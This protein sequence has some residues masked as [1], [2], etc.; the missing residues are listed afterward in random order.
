M[1][2]TTW[3]WSCLC[4]GRSTPR[5]FG[6]SVEGMGNGERCR[7]YGHL[8]AMCHNKGE[9]RNESEQTH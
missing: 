2:P 1:Q 6:K 4:E 7:L 9:L 8:P 3:G 5:V